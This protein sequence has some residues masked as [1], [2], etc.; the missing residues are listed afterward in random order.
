MRNTYL[1]C[2]M[3]VYLP[4]INTSLKEFCEMWNNHPVR[5]A[6]NRTPAQL[7]VQSV[8]SM[9][10]PDDGDVPNELYGID[11][12]GPIPS[13]EEDSAAE[14]EVVVPNMIL[15]CQICRHS[16]CRLCVILMKTV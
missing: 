10:N 13:D 16:N 12:K 14:D 1:H 9:Y 15:F 4:R 2:I 6:Q 8:M 7:M 3:Y 11:E 5:T